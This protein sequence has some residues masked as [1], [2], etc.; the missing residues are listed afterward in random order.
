MVRKRKLESDAS[1]AAHQDTHDESS[2]TLTL[3][4]SNG[5]QTA[6]DDSPPGSGQNGKL[7]ND[8]RKKQ[9]QP[10]IGQACDRCRVS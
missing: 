1:D 8:K 7:S 2:L 10:R 5:Q 3:Q 9:S 4:Q 6:Q